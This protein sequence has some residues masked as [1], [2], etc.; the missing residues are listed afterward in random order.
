[1]SEVSEADDEQFGR[2]GMVGDLL[3][4][5]R[6]DNKPS[7]ERLGRFRFHLLS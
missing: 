3:T 1:V 6:S 2:H 4:K 7:P 5:T